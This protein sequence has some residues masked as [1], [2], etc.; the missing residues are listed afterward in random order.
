MMK[1]FLTYLDNEYDIE[2]INSFIII[3]HFLRIRI[4]WSQIDLNRII[5]ICI[6]SVSCWSIITCAC[7][8]KH[9]KINISFRMRIEGN[10]KNVGDFH[11]VF[12]PVWT[13]GIF[14]ANKNNKF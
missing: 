7:R 8:K 6:M 11:F 9:R 4:H 5:S 12:L 14:N 3:K 2:S 13:S 10:E 1:D